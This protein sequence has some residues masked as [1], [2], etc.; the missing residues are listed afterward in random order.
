MAMWFILT[1]RVGGEVRDPSRDVLEAAIA[2]VVD[3]RYAGDIEHADVFVRCGYDDGP[4][5]VLNYHTSRRLT[6]EQWADPDFEDEL[7]PA[8]YLFDVSHAEAVRLMHELRTGR[9]EH[10]RRAP[11]TAAE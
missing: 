7:A 3:S 11:W 1:K 8:G 2:E 10:I 6:F 9:L 5:Y 4:M